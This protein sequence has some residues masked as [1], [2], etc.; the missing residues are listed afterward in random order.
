MADVAK[1]NPS[2]LHTLFGSSSILVSYKYTCLVSLFP[3][4][5]SRKM[6][7]LRIADPNKRNVLVRVY[8]RLAGKPLAHNSRIQDPHIVYSMASSTLCVASH[9]LTHHAQESFFRS[10]R[11]IL[12][13]FVSDVYLFPTL[14]KIESRYNY[15]A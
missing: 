6:F 7:L 9:Q 2:Y 8:L 14:A 4:M 5:K 10:P 15:F 1:T 13:F 11:I 12:E 3:C